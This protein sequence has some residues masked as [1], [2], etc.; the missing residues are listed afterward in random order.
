[1]AEPRQWTADEIQDKFVRYL[2]D[3]ASYWANLD[4][5]KT[6]LERVEGAIFSTLVTLDGESAG[7][8]GFIVAPLGDKSDISFYKE[9]DENWYPVNDGSKIKGDIGGS[10]HEAFCK[11]RDNG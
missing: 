8:P 5:D 1:M 6:I 2:K 11:L 9:R 4:A 7:L 3:I 10:L